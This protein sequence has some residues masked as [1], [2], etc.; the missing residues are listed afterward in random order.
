MSS[1]R[2]NTP[3][4]SLNSLRLMHSSQSKM[5]TAIQR[6][7]SGLRINTSKDDTAS[8]AINHRMKNQIMGKKMAGRNIQ[9]GSNLIQTAEDGLNQIQSILTRMRELAIQSA[10]DNLNPNDRASINLEFNHL[11]DEVQRIAYSTEYNQMKLLAPTPESLTTQTTF[12]TNDVDMGIVIDT[13]GSM[14][15]NDATIDL[16]QDGTSEANIDRMQAAKVAAQLL[17]DQLPE[18][19]GVGLIKNVGAISV[20][21]PTSGNFVSKDTITNWTSVMTTDHSQIKSGINTLIATGGENNATA[22]EAGQEMLQGGSNQDM[23]VFLTDAGQIGNTASI[24]A[25]NLVKEAGI[26]L[27]AI[28]VGGAATASNLQLIAS[29]PYE[30]NVFTNHVGA[31]DSIDLDQIFSQIAQEVVEVS[32]SEEKT[33]EINQF[34]I[35]MDA[36]NSVENQLSVEIK[37]ATLDSLSLLATNLSTLD[38]S[39]TAISQLDSAIN[40]VN[41]QRSNLG[42]LYNRLELA[43]S[44]LMTG[45]QYLESSLSTIR[46]A[47]FAVESNNLVRT[48]ILTQ[49]GTS[50]LAQANQISQ[51]VLSLL[52]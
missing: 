12:T 34:Q 8:M 40:F 31:T 38:Q 2:I 7:S 20:Y 15:N 1:A 18:G 17:V 22:L 29:E 43:Q 26:R 46:D 48:Q 27:I 21:N 49:S 16:D 25:A 47:D 41:E 44:N 19:T 3:L 51:N 33:T 45:I 9:Q 50:M 37:T 39:Q 24:A 5:E 10:S 35:Q 52:K 36:T 6:L 11:K 13:S 30:D 23:M 32:A 4:S 14:T 28:G 42:A